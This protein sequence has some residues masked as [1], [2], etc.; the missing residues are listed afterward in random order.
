M[1]YDINDY[2]HWCEETKRWHVATYRDGRYY[3]GIPGQRGQWYGPLDYVNGYTYK[4]RSSAI[5]AAKRLYGLDNDGYTE[6]IC[7]NNYA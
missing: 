4:H 3:G 1:E 5:R 2:V 6:T 7:Q